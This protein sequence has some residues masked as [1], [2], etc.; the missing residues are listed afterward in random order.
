VKDTIEQRML[1]LQQMK[2]ELMTNSFTNDKVENREQ[3][4]RDIQML[5]N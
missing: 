4:I 3:R 2:R 1:D 5:M